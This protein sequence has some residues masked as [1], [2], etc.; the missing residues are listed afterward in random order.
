MPTNTHTLNAVQVDLTAFDP[1]QLSKNPTAWD[2]IN[3]ADILVSS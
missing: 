2:Q 1:Q 3:V